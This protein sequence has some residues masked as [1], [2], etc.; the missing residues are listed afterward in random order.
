LHLARPPT[1]EK[2][3]RFHPLFTSPIGSAMSLNLAS[4]LRNSANRYPNLTA[5]IDGAAR[6]SYARLDEAARWFAG[7]LLA[8]GVSPGDCVAIMVPNVPEFTVAYFGILYAGCVVVPLNTLLV[9]NEVE[10]QLEDSEARALLVHA[11]TAGVGIEAASRVS[12]CRRIYTIG[13]ECGS[14]STGTKRFEKVIES[15]APADL[16]QTSGDD[17]AVI[18]YTSGT[19]G[20]PKGAELT[21]FGLYYNAQLVAER[22]FGRWPDR[23]VVLQPQDVGLAALPLYHAFGQTNIQNAL[24]FSGG[25]ISYMLR[26]CPT[27]AAQLMARD[28]VTFFAGVPTMYIG[29]LN[30]PEVSDKQLASVKYCVSG[31]AALPIEVKQNF[32]QRF[33]LAVQE[34]YGLTETSPLACIQPI[35]EA[36]K[37]GT[38]GKPAF[39]VEMKIFDDHDREVSQGE[40]GEIVIRGHNIMKGY[41]KRPEA[42]A[43]AMR[44]G[45]FHSGDIGYVDEEGDFFIVDRKKDLIIRGGYNVYPREVEE[46]LYAHPAIAEAAVI[47]VPDARLGEEVKAVIAFKT[48]MSASVDEI[49]QHCKEQVAAYKYPRIVTILDS[50]PKGPTGKILKRGLRE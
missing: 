35:D 7:E 20:K 30:D 2:Q 16:A 13:V 42:T 29:L 32:T 43:A 48:G 46:A 37:A 5:T 19:T 39:G 26:F 14:Q 12:G 31:G 25:A 1:Q 6:M 18:L 28:R 27:D 9:A 24:L 4:V 33:G 11:Q 50:L 23:I 40:R 38:I 49:I 47:G 44:N 34:G 21:H 3:A 17:T 45:W 36:A 10:F 8:S 22:N 41:F 15:G